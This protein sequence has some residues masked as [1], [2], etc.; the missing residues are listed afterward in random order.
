MLRR[1]A[2]GGKPPGNANM[3]VAVLDAG[4]RPPSDHPGSCGPVII[5]WWPPAAE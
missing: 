5:F 3:A 1:G 4:G 2:A